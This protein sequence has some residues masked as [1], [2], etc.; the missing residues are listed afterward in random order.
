MLL[1]LLVFWVHLV[2]GRHWVQD[3]SE[4]SDTAHR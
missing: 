1:L 4:L 3:T 2:N